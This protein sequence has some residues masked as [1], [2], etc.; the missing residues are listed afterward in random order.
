MSAPDAPQDNSYA[1]AQLEGQRADEARARDKA[2]AE[3]KKAELAGLRQSSAGMARN[4]STQYLQSLGLDP[5]AYSGDIDREINNILSGI[6][7][8]DENPGSYFKTAPQDIYGN[9]T[10]NFQTKNQTDIDRIFSPNYE[11]SKINMNMDD[12]YIA[13]ILS[14]QRGNADAIIQN[15]LKRGVL[16]DTGAA[17]ASADLDRQSSGIRTKLNTI[18]DTVLAGGQQKLRD[19]ANRARTDAG[20]LKLGQTFDPNSYSKDADQVFNDFVASM[21]D[22]LRSNVT[23]NLFQTNGLA[24]VGGAAQGAGNTKYNPR[25]AAGIFD[26]TD[27]TKKT[28][29]SSESIF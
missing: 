29:A 16:T 15:M 25:A 18:G 21:G 7:P 20:T 24:A 14:E 6:N 22:Q 2:D 9:L 17:G 8:A 27:E 11:T 26:T 19:V 10:R 28:P 23:G 3:A 4:N 12:P 13:D 5:N 1:V